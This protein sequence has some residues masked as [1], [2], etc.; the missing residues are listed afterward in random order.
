[1]K[2]ISIHPEYCEEIV[3]GEKPEEFRS[4]NTQYRGD[5][6]IVSTATKTYQG[7]AVCV[8]ELY[9]VAYDYER[10]YNSYSCFRLMF[11]NIRPVVPFYVKGRPGFYEADT[12]HMR[13]LS[14]ISPENRD[15][16]IK[17]AMMNLY[18]GGAK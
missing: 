8:A 5:L 6:L 7:H 4:W 16:N 9:D 11:R 2:A 13:F 1:M 14:E 10:E 15:I 18:K 12:T 3:S 17:A